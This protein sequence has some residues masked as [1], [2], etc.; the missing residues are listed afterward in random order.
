MVL[1]E[2]VATE[3]PQSGALDTLLAATRGDMLKVNDD[4][5][6]PREIAC[7]DDSR[8]SRAT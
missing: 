3:Q 2:A 6:R 7:R 5:P 8:R 4:D 1:S